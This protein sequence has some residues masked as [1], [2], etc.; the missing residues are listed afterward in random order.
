MIQQS[1]FI[2]VRDTYGYNTLREILLPWHVCFQEER[3][4]LDCRQVSLPPNG[5]GHRTAWL[6]RG[7][8]RR[9]SAGA[10]ICSALRTVSLPPV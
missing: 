2:R 5:T 10:L 3:L 8:I 4:V 6:G 9:A 1:I 7:E